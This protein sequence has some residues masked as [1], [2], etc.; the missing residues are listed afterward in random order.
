MGGSAGHVSMSLSK[1]FPDLKFIVQDFKETVEA[2]EKTLP[3]DFQGKISYQ[4]HDFFNPQV[5]HGA[6][7]YMMRHICHCWPDKYLIKILKGI[8]P[9][10]APR[11][12]IVV[13]ETIVLPPGHYDWLEERWARLVNIFELDVALC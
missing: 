2:N 10:M 6:D 4:A 5:A 1:K 9:A 8:V 11:S 7:V 3:A 12:K 13:V